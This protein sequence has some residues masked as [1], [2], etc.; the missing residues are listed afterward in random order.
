MLSSGSTLAP[1][2][3]PST[4]AESPL[5]HRTKPLTNAQKFTA[6]VAEM[7]LNISK[8][9]KTVAAL[10]HANDTL[11]NEM[12]HMEERFDEQLNVR[13]SKSEITMITNLQTLESRVSDKRKRVLEDEDDDDDKEVIKQELRSIE[14]SE[15]ASHDNGLLVSYITC[16]IENAHYIHPGSDSFHV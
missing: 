3:T 11:K 6:K 1:Y 14:L 13:L 9:E 4:T 16:T 5:G 15:H 8:L 12:K 2:A 10:Q 7:E